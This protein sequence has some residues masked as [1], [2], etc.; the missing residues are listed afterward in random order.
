MVKCNLLLANYPASYKLGVSLIFLIVLLFPTIFRFWILKRPFLSLW[1]LIPYS[2]IYGFSLSVVFEVWL[3]WLFNYDMSKLPG[4]ISVLSF[5]VCSAYTY[6]ISKYGYLKYL[7][8]KTVEDNNE[9][10]TP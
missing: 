2:L 10:I 3:S 6:V 7:V 5:L 4:N 8:N 9:V 1:T